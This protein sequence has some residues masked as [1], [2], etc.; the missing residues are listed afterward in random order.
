MSEWRTIKTAPKDG[1]RIL[2]CWAEGDG[3]TIIEWFSYNMWVLGDM[4]SGS[5]CQRALG[6]GSDTGYEDAAFSH[7]MPLPAL[8]KKEVNDD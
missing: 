1:T 8:P 7:W 3:H 6:L 5:W 2:A 4:D